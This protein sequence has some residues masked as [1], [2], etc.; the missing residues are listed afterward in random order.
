MLATEI[1]CVS[2]YTNDATLLKASVVRVPP[3]TFWS[4]PKTRSTTANGAAQRIDELG[5]NPNF[6]PEGLTLRSA[7]E[8]GS[9]EKLIDMIEEDL[10]AERIVIER[11]LPRRVVTPCISAQIVRNER[12]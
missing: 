1:V 5:G 3:K 12:V 9:A 10:V 7:T 2:R 11:Y 6:N 8:Y 4:T